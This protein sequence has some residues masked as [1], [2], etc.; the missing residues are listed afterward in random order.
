MN[1]VSNKPNK[2]NMKTN[3]HTGYVIALWSVTVQ[4]PGQA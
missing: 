2:K 1:V 3:L 4:V